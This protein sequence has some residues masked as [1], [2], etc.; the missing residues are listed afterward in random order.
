MCE[1][2]LQGEKILLA[3]T[4]VGTDYYELPDGTCLMHVQEDGE[5][6]VCLNPHPFS[7]VKEAL[8]RDSYQI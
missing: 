1:I 3:N 8:A 2:Q 6:Y 7:A 5:E 4:D